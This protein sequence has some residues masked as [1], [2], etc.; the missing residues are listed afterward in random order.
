ME[1]K[2]GGGRGGDLLHKPQIIVLLIN[3]SF[4]S[5]VIPTKK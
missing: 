2:E 5:S 4:A 3:E 1:E